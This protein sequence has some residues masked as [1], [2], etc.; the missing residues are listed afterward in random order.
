MLPYG[1]IIRESHSEVE[2]TKKY[3]ETTIFSHFLGSFEKN[4]IKFKFLQN[5]L[6][7]VGV[8]KRFTWSVLMPN[9][10][11]VAS[12]V[13]PFWI[14]EFSDWKID[15]PLNFGRGTKVRHEGGRVLP[16]NVPW[17]FEQNP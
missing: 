3:Q 8:G 17:K 10:A 2:N 9:T 4:S 11:Y 14:F 6:F 1:K 7:E 15:G 12:T 13:C 5:F 16:V